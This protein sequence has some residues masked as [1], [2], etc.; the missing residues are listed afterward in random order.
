MRK[1]NNVR[2][3]FMLAYEIYA[4]E[5]LKTPRPQTTNHEQISNM[6]SYFETQHGVNYRGPRGMTLRAPS[7]LT[8]SDDYKVG[9]GV[10]TLPWGDLDTFI[11]NEAA[12][13]A[14][15]NSQSTA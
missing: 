7:W 13:I 2:A 12:E 5:V 15:K 6:L 10:F 3:N 8:N 1:M 14:A 9:R 11:Q 4:N